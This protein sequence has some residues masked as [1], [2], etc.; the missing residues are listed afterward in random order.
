MRNHIRRAVFLVTSCCA[1]AVPLPRTL[2]GAYDIHVQLNDTFTDAVF[3]T[4][5]FDFPGSAVAVDQAGAI[6]VGD[7]FSVV[8]NI[9][10]GADGMVSWG[11]VSGLLPNGRTFGDPLTSPSVEV[12]YAERNG[13]YLSVGRIETGVDMVGVQWLA[14]DDGIN[15]T[16]SGAGSMLLDVILFGAP[17]T[18]VDHDGRLLA[19][20]LDT[21]RSLVTGAHVRLS[22]P[23]AFSYDAFITDADFVIVPAAGTSAVFAAA[24]LS[25]GRRRRPNRKQAGKA[26][27]KA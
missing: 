13:A 19:P 3:Y 15:G 27:A 16:G 8:Q 2:G 12:A 21:F 17:G 1:L 20:D 26:G 25:A 10:V 23:A 11:G 22:Y 4:N 24:A 18:L 14:S 5:P 6:S 9:Q 7:P